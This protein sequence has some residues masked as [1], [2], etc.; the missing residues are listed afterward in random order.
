[1]LNNAPARSNAP[2]IPLDK[3][4]LLGFDLETTG[5]DTNTARVV[6]AHL[7]L[8]LPGPAG[9]APPPEHTHDFLINPGVEIPTGASDIHG[10]TT[11]MAVNHG[12]APT[13]PAR[14][15]PRIFELINYYCLP[16]MHNNYS[17]A[18]LVG[19]N[20]AYDL[21]LLEAERV[22]HLSAAPHPSSADYPPP[23]PP[24]RFPIG[25]ASE[26]HP[27][28]DPTIAVVDG[29]VLDK[30]LSPFRKGSRKL[31]ALA[32]VYGVP[33]TAEDAH[34]AAADAIASTAI[35]RKQLRALE[36][37][38][39]LTVSALKALGYAPGGHRAAPRLGPTTLHMLQAGWHTTQARS[40]ANY[41]RRTPGKSDQ[42]VELGW[43]IKTGEY[44]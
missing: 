20:L 35:V 3:R 28:E 42:K 9:Q 18:L 31:T 14:G 41:F 33:L 21:S 1:M 6:T 44:A 8:H 36:Q 24:L 40:L 5:I 15:L 34:N 11:E 12:S 26:G 4:P 13:D 7:S 43:P 38:P 29:Y 22:R 16:A 27:P 39:H 25:P 30:F 2:H 17:P 10:I 19:F 32:R 23:T 37:T